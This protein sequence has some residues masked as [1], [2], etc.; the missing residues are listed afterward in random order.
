MEQASIG[1][2]LSPFSQKKN[3]KK[4]LILDNFQIGQLLLLE[5][6]GLLYLLNILWTEW[7]T[8]NFLLQY[9]ETYQDDSIMEIP[10]LLDV[11]TD[12]GLRRL[13]TI[14]VWAP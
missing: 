12:L 13:L 14:P 6:M 1:S 9:S 10:S 7:K 5:S 8:I 2:W 3:F 4:I 11:Q